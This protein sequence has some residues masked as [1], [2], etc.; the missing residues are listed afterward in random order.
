MCFFLLL[1]SH[2]KAVTGRPVLKKNVS[3]NLNQ[4]M[5]HTRL[6]DTVHIVDSCWNITIKT[7]WLFVCEGKCLCCDLIRCNQDIRK[8]ASSIF[9]QNMNGC[10][11]KITDWIF[12]CFR[13]SIF[14]NKPSFLLKVSSEPFIASFFVQN[15]AALTWPEWLTKPA[16]EILAIISVWNPTRHFFCSN[17][18][19][20]RRLDFQF[21][22]SHTFHFPAETWQIVA[23]LQH[24]TPKEQTHKAL[25]L[26]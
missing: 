23:T 20:R 15:Q 14:N 12:F 17:W 10:T 16:E 3:R 6:K 13:K 8:L 19:E 1:T 11:Y 5:I 7:S 26:K 25:S 2:T 22:A 4:V 9:S 21:W 24:M 18:H